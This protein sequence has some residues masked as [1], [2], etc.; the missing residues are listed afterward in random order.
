MLAVRRD[1]VNGMDI[2]ILAQFFPFFV[3]VG[4]MDWRSVLRSERQP[5]S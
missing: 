5:L 3:A 2:G 4:R 1:D